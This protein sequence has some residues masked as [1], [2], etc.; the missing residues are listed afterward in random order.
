MTTAAEL[1][2]IL[3]EA[4]GMPCTAARIAVYDQVLRH[5][6]EAG[7]PEL[8]FSAHIEATDGYV[9]GGEPARAFAPSA[10]HKRRYL[11]GAR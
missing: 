11:V 10:V 3:D 4:R 6:D 2:Q 7:D 9:S 5:I 1:R 8:A